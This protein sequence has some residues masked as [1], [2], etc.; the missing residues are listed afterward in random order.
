MLAKLNAPPPVELARDIGNEFIDSDM[1]FRDTQLNNKAYLRSKDQVNV[2]LDRRD[3]FMN[4]LERNKHQQ[5]LMT[6]MA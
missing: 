1:H 2:L 5:D 3:E 6:I 4:E